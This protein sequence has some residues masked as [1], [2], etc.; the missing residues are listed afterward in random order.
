MGFEQ[1]LPDHVEVAAYYTVSEALTNASKH[2]N[3][4]RV[5]VSLRV[6]DN[7]LLLTIRDDGVGGAD[8]NRGS[9]LTGL[10]D[11]IES[12]GGQI[13]IESPSGG[14]TLIE[15]EIPI[16]RPAGRNDERDELLSPAA[17]AGS[18]S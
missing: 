2:A 4:M 17:T 9:G 3:A 5:W 15:V 13:K 12:L 8:A 14:G 6:E 16:G 10:R 7:M 11:R 18:S 1:R